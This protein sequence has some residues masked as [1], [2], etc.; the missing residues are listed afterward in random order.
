MSVQLDPKRVA[1]FHGNLYR[2]NFPLIGQEVAFNQ[3][4]ELLGA[5]TNSIVEICLTDNTGE[6]PLL[7]ILERTYDTKFTRSAPPFDDA[8]WAPGKVKQQPGQRHYVCWWP[9][10]GGSTPDVLGPD[11]YSYDFIGLIEFLVNFQLLENSKVYI[12]CMN[13]TDRTGA[14]VAGYAMRALKMNIHDAFKLANAVPAAGKMS[15]P[16]VELVNAYGAHL[17]GV[18]LPAGLLTR[19]DL[20]T[21]APG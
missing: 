13:G 12:H 15:Q 9:I 3:L 14:V 16:Y 8:L 20:G 1:Q 10:E 19:H 11:P 2:G 5:Q 21:R 7:E 4:T 18:V 17:A 6:L